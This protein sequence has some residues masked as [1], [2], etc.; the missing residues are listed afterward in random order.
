MIHVLAGPVW[1]AYPSRRQNNARLRLTAAI[2]SHAFAPVW[3]R[4]RM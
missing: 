2:N 1:I 3:C 4:T